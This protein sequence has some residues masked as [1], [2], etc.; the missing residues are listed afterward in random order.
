MNEDVFP[1]ENEDFPAS[2]VSELRGVT[3]QIMVE[4]DSNNRP[5]KR[6]FSSK[7]CAAVLAGRPSKMLGPSKQQR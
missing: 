6:W 5:E 1:I 7:T 2:H 4:T 3:R